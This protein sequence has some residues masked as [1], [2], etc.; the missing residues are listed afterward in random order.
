MKPG[1]RSEMIAIEV[2]ERLKRLIAAM[3]E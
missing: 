2:A 3:P 1:M